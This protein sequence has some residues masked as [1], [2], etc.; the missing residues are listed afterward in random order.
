M[1]KK[2]IFYFVGSFLFSM[3]AVS[4]IVEE[5]VLFLFL[6]NLSFFQFWYILILFFLNTARHRWFSFQFYY[7]FPFLLI[8]FYL[9]KFIAYVFG[10]TIIFSSFSVQDFIPLSIVIINFLCFYVV[11]VRMSKMRWTK[12]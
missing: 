9:I 10:A 8:D 6:S 3:L 1:S 4:M 12:N 2:F 7:H 11:F 5:N